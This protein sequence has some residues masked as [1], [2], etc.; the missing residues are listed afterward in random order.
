MHHAWSLLVWILR[1][2]SK[3]VVLIRI[4]TRSCSR[5]QSSRWNWRPKFCCTRRCR[6]L[7][8]TH[9]PTGRISTCPSCPAR[10]WC[11]SGAS[12][13]PATSPCSTPCWPT[14]TTGPSPPPCSS[15][16]T[17]VPFC[18]KTSVVAT[19]T[20]HRQWSLRQRRQQP[21]WRRQPMA[22]C[23]AW[24]IHGLRRSWCPTPPC[25]VCPA[26]T[27]WP[28]STTCC[29]T[30]GSCMPR[31]CG[32]L[33]STSRMNTTRRVSTALSCSPRGQRTS[34]LLT[35]WRTISFAG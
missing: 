30:T 16:P 4:S 3:T 32:A 18:P 19:T 2:S 1:L 9:R 12:T 33:A 13:S 31:G 7:T 14:S 20:P 21:R 29:V 27:C 10:S 8:S 23:E 35:A 28:A 15:S 5:I 34:P 22:F 25:E 11:A 6:R 17:G 26:P 24:V